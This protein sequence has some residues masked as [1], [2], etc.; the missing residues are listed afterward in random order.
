MTGTSND[1]VGPDITVADFGAC[2]DAATPAHT[3]AIDST[4][5]TMIFNIYPGILSWIP[6]SAISNAE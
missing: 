5:A 1:E 3:C 6:T 2:M 4:K